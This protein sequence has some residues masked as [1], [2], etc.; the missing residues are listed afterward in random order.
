MKR[1]ISLA[2]LAGLCAGQVSALSCL[3]PDVARAFTTAA[4][5]EE[6]YVVLLGSFAF[7]AP[8]AS[9]SDNPARET[10]VDSVFTG[11]SL[12]ATGFQPNAPLDVTLKFTCAGPWCGSIPDDGTQVLAFVERTA[13]GYVFEVGPCYGSAFV[14]PRA[15]DIARVEACMQGDG[16]AEGRSR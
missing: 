1:V 7:D 6:T 15:G 8:G 9:G 12:G 11:Q 2:V 4:E 16:C 3:R 14:A 13:A 10:Q 5:A